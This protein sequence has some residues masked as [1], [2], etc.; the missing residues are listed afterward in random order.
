MHRLKS[1]G[2]LSSFFT[3]ESYLGSVLLHPP[4]YTCVSCRRVYVHVFI[5]QTAGKGYALPIYQMDLDRSEALMR[6]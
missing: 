1:L 2:C 4:V 6:C 5:Q 3:T